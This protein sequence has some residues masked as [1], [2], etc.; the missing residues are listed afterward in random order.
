M[1]IKMKGFCDVCRKEFDICNG[2]FRIEHHTVADETIHIEVQ[3]LAKALDNGNLNHEDFHVCGKHCL[4]RQLD[5]IIGDERVMVNEEVEKV[6]SEN[7][8][9]T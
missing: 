2:A 5:N 6:E 3:R 8:H 9:S 4:F 1:S 7:I